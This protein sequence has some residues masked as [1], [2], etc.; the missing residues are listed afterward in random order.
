MKALINTS[1][2]CCFVLLFTANSMAQYLSDM[3]KGRKFFIQ[4]ALN[5]GKN[6]GGYWDV[7]GTPTNIDKGSNI[8]LWDIDGGFDRQFSLGNSMMKGY[9]EIKVG[10]VRVNVDGGKSANGTNVEVWDKDNAPKQMFR[11]K[12]LGNGRFKIYSKSG[13]VVC[14][15]G[16]SS[17]NGSNVHIWDDHDGGW[18]EWYLIDAATR[19]TFIPQVSNTS[20][21]SNNNGCIYTLLCTSGKKRK[22]RENQKLFTFKIKC[23]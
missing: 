1:L 23:L 3:P 15:A 6:N 9:Y 14:T 17:S 22:K 16:R 8:Q 12:H 5:Y 19:Q 7:P 21:L 13:K 10:T 2:V 4:S 11:F 18:M 20:S